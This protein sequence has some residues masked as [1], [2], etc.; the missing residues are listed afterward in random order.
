M[1][2]FHFSYMTIPTERGI[3]SE[4]SIHAVIWIGNCAWEYTAVVSPSLPLVWDGFLHSV[5]LLV[6][7]S[8]FRL[9]RLGLMEL[10]SNDEPGFRR[11]LYILL[12]SRL[13]DFVAFYI[14]ILVPSK[15]PLHPLLARY[16]DFSGLFIWTIT[17]SNSQLTIIHVVMVVH[18]PPSVDPFGSIQHSLKFFNIQNKIL[19]SIIWWVLQHEVLH[20]RP[21][22]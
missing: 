17:C 3:P 19:I 22:S 4:N 13:W 20:H 18:D 11:P 15:T 16:P 2:E 21:E 8:E 6:Q 14:S 12:P 7:P 10:S 1:I 9:P 5:N